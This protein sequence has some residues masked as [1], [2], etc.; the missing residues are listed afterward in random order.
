MVARTWVAT[1]NDRTCWCSKYAE[2]ARCRR[3]HLSDTAATEAANSASSPDS[4]FD[5]SA[6]GSAAIEPTI[7]S[8]TAAAE[9]FTAAAERASAGSDSARPGNHETRAGIG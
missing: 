6:G 9:P 2:S 1:A 5:T 7:E 8:A 3:E 4:F